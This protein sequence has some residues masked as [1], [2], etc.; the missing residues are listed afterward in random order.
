MG[1]LKYNSPLMKPLISDSNRTIRIKWA[2]V[3]MQIDWDTVVFS[4]ET[5]VMLFRPPSRVWQRRGARFPFWTVKHPLKLHVWGCFSSV[6]FGKIS[7]SP[8]I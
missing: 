6:G 4:D 8:K 7:C 3:H 2:K 5:T 1:G